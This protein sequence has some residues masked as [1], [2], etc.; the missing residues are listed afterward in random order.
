[1]FLLSL[2]VFSFW[3]DLTLL[4]L[5]LEQSSLVFR[6]YTKRYI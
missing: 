1:M 6:G 3:A 2:V 5:I 4:A